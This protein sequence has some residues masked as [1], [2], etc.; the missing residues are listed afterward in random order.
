M[1]KKAL[2]RRSRVADVSCKQIV[3]GQA[4]PPEEFARILSFT[5]KSILDLDILRAD[6]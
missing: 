4:C 6:R 5:I 3:F 2:G 1:P